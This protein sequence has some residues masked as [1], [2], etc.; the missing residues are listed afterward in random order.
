MAASR[1]YTLTTWDYH[2]DSVII[3]FLADYVLH[4]FHVLWQWNNNA[5]VLWLNAETAA[6]VLYSAC[7]C[8]ILSTGHTRCKVVGDNNYDVC[9]LVYSIEQSCHTRVCEGRVADNCN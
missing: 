3:D 4:L 5:H 1:L 8:R 6:D 2:A 9:L 7:S